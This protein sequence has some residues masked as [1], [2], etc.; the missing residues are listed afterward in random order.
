MTAS[1][2]TGGSGR[3]SREHY[4][5]DAGAG[6][7]SK[8]SSSRPSGRACPDETEAK[9]ECGKTLLAGKLKDEPRQAGFSF[10]KLFRTVLRDLRGRDLCVHLSAVPVTDSSKKKQTRRKVKSL[11]FCFVQRASHKH[12]KYNKLWR[13]TATR[14]KPRVQALTATNGQYYPN[15]QFVQPN[16]HCTVCST[17]YR[18]THNKQRTN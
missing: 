1:A 3:L 18:Y 16:N 9:N 5:P 12:G 8:E 7:R 2:L 13:K 11:E 14:Q 15:P 4:E 10:P 6:N 17:I